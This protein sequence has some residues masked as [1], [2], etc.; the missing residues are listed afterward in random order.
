M[1][2]SQTFYQMQL[3]WIKALQSLLRSPAVDSFF[4]LWSCVDTIYFSTLIIACV[5]Y[6]WDRRVGVRLFYL[7][8]ISLVLNQLLKFFFH[9]PRPCQ[10]DPLVGVFC[11]LEPGFPS[12]AAQTATILA[13][14]V[15]LETRRHLYRVLALIFAFFLCFSR[16][17]LGMHYPADILG[18]IFI[19]GLLLVLY[20]LAFPKL[21]KHWKALSLVFPFALLLIGF[22]IPITYSWSLYF[23]CAT[24]GVAFGL[25][26]EEKMGTKKMPPL[27]MR[28]W[29]VTSVIVGLALL[30]LFGKLEPW[31]KF[32]TDMSQG[33]WLSFLGAWII[34]KKF[35]QK[36]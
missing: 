33:Y 34:P 2:F 3:E 31:L 13:G 19:G 29:Q 28:G 9:Y 21:E 8:V 20:A 7:L 11:S 1:P 6:L 26:T 22:R 30:F 16:V 17:Y 24:L 35:L 14:I 12:G 32:V 36:R 25:M 18:G 10:V 23:F 15:F 4:K 27:M 5:W